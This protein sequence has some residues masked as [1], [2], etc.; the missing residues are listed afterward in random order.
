M[1]PSLSAN[2][3][4][5]FKIFNKLLEIF[6]FIQSIYWLH[7]AC[8]ASIFVG[9][10]RKERPRLYPRNVVFLAIFLKQCSLLCHKQSSSTISRSEN[11]FHITMSAKAAMFPN[12]RTLLNHCIFATMMKVYLEDSSR[13]SGKIFTKISDFTY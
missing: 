8:T 6:I 5:Y 1:R 11:A 9:L 4:I 10:R 7:L 12:G 3:R 2:I 13:I